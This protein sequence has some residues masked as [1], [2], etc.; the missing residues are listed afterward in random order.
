MGGTESAAHVSALGVLVAFGA[1]MSRVPGSGSSPARTFFFLFALSVGAFAIVTGL[2]ERGEHVPMILA[3]FGSS[4]CGWSW[5]LAR[6]IFRPGEPTGSWALAMVGLM[7][8]SAAIVVAAAPS[9]R[10]LDANGGALRILINLNGLLSSTVLTLALFEPFHAWSSDLSRV[11]RRFRT[12]FA[13]GYLLLLAVGV[14]W[15]Q[16]AV[17]DSPPAQWSST[18]KLLCALAALV[19]ADFALRFRL[20]HPLIAS[21]RRRRPRPVQP[22]DNALA[23]RVRR[24]FEHDHVYTDAE[25]RVAD[26]ARRLGEPDYRVSRCISGALEFRNF[27]QMVN[28]YRIDAAKRMLESEACNDRSILEIALDA[29][30]ASIGPFNRAFKRQVG[31]TPSEFRK[32]NG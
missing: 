16:N 10:S 30:F 3:I 13:G 17:D 27:N 8:V 23:D 5:L 19:G 9:G 2:D 18:L 4:A 11:E 25:L 28:H 14:L 32:R 12:V 7:V 6:A 26:L 21:R 22:E 20:G 15:I 1:A 31:M 24:A 29:G